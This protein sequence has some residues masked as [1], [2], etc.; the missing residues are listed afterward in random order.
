MS[1][2]HAAYGGLVVS[3]SRETCGSGVL[4]LALIVKRRGLRLYALA[5]LT[6]AG[7]SV[8]PTFYTGYEAAH[9]LRDTR[10]IVR[11]TAEEH[12]EQAGESAARTTGV[13]AGPGQLRLRRSVPACAWSVRVAADLRSHR[14]VGASS[15]CR[16]IGERISPCRPR[17]PPPVMRAA[18]SLCRWPVSHRL[19]SAA[20]RFA[21]RAT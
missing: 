20:G 17:L 3:K 19:A 21:C 13:A 2:R 9:A 1:A 4:T 12:D 10:Y 11:S 14:S 6:L 5:T 8:Y 7:L 18:R 15:P 16:S